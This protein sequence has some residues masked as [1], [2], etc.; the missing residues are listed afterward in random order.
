MPI[1]KVSATG[2]NTRG[3]TSGLSSSSEAGAPYVNAHA[4]ICAGDG[5][6]PVPYRDEAKERAALSLRRECHGG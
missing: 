3:L 4:R 6:K 1:N 5:R 2:F